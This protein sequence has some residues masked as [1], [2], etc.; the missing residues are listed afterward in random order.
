MPLNPRRGREQGGRRDRGDE[1][2]PTVRRSENGGH[3]RFHYERPTEDDV[4]GQ[5]KRA[6]SASRF[7]LPIKRGVQL[8]KPHDGENWV[9]ILP[10]TWPSPFTV[11]GETYKKHWAYPV[12]LHRFVGSE[13]GTYVCLKK[14]LGQPC[15]CCDA[16]LEEREHGDLEFSRKLQASLYW[17]AWMLDRDGKEPEKPQVWSISET[18]EQEILKQTVDRQTDAALIISDPNE[19][20]DLIFDRTKLGKDPK[21]VKYSGWMFGRESCPIFDDQGAQDEVLQFIHDNPIPEQLLFREPDYLEKVMAGTGGSADEDLDD[22]DAENYGSEGD[23]Q[24]AS[25]NAGDDG[26]DDQNDQ[27]QDDQDAGDEADIQQAAGDDEGLPDDAGDTPDEAVDEERAEPNVRQQQRRRPPIHA[28]N[29]R[30][31]Q[32]RAERREGGRSSRGGGRPSRPT[33]RGGAS[34]SGRPTRGGGRPSG[35]RGRPSGGR[36][37]GRSR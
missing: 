16:A 6:Q 32:D 19:G 26:T 33:P 17:F 9:R 13:G 1:R 3:G 30:G 5:L 11:N 22:T 27:P 29:G 24:G 36:P 28:S 25:D 20:Y 14:Q 8:F 34:A 21:N 15:A 31:E 35:S 10:Q 37:S 2:R 23:D 7:D 12:W 4:R 18:Q